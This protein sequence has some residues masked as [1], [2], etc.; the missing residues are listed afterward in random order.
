MKTTNIER[1]VFIDML[2]GFAILVMIM[3]HTNAY[4]LKTPISFFIWDWGQFAVPVFIFCASYVF[5]QKQQTFSTFSAFFKYLKKRLTRLLVPYYI[6]VLIFCGLFLLKDPS[7]ITFSYVWHNL[8]I[9]GGI[10]INW[11]VLLFVFFSIIMPFISWSYTNNKTLFY[12]F[13][14]ASIISSIL[15]V[16]YKFPYN[17]RLIMWLPWSLLVV[18]SYF[19]YKFERNKLFMLLGF[20]TSTFLF[21]VFYYLQSYLKHSLIMYDNKYPPNFYHLTFCIS[22]IFFICWVGKINKLFFFPVKQYLDF[23]SKNS[24]SIYFIHYSIIFILFAFTKIKFNWLTFFI[25]TT[26]ITSICQF[27]FNSLYIIFSRHYIKGQ[28]SGYSQEHVG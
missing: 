25:A 14:T 21:I 7:K 13:T 27:I 22:S 16:F 20:A 17:Y 24:Y 15:L 18:V 11:L 3:L 2:R 19:I 6:F 8:T 10:D 26:A 5:F 4:F 23:L 28:Q 9:N 1:V 12:L